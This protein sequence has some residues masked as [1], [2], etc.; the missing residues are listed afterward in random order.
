M[1]V[2]FGMTGSSS[3]FD[4]SEIVDADNDV[5]DDGRLKQ[6]IQSWIILIWEM[7]TTNGS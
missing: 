7:A 3:K 1:G 2:E 6:T 5:D 4:G